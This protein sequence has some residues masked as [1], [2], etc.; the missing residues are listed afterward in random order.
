MASIN[1]IVSVARGDGEADGGGAATGRAE[2]DWSAESPHGQWQC[3][4][5]E[6]DHHGHR[7]LHPRPTAGG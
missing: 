1:S 6:S 2:W 3:V 5:P 4:R 7:V